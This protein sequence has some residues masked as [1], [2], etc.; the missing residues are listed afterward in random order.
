MRFAALGSGSRGNAWLVEGGGSALLV[1]CGFPLRE[2]RARLARLGYAPEQLA[3]V[4]LT[5]E[6]GD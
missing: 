6:H 5:H 2:T 3:G 1:D 4:V